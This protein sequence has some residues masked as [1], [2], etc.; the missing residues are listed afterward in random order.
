[1]LFSTFVLLST[2]LAVNAVTLEK[3]TAG[4][5]QNPSGS[6]SFTVYS[7]CGSPGDDNHRSHLRPVTELF[8]TIAC[9]KT[10][11]GF[12]AAMNQLAFGAPPNL[13][14]GDACGRCFSLTGTADPYSPAFTGPFNSI[15]VKV[16]NLW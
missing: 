9:G 4:Y 8:L 10:G 1:M 3:R 16:T 5:V 2:L 13:G 15:V 11:S 6:A 12:T 14:P 7:G